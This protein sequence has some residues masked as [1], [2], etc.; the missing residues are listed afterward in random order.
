MRKK[1][2]YAVLFSVFTVA[3]LTGCGENGTSNSDAIITEIGDTGEVGDVGA[4]DAAVAQEA[5]EATEEIG[6]SSEKVNLETG[7]STKNELPPDE[8]YAGIKLSDALAQVKLQ[9][10]SGGEILEYSEDAD[11]DG[12]L[13][14]VVVTAPVTTADGPVNVTYYVTDKDCYT[15]EEETVET[16]TK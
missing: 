6:E 9:I 1:I 10:G 4:Q 13:A 5:R 14:W 15:V 3:A 11:P 12:N 7:E 2:C 8:E 16:E